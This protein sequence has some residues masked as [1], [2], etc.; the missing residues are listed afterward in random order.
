M[1]MVNWYYVYVMW[2]ILMLCIIKNMVFMVVKWI[3]C[4]YDG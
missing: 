1:E 4:N 2:M 3:E